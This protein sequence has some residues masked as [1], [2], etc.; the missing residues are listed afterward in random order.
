MPL[1]PSQYIFP[2][3]THLGHRQEIQTDRGM[4]RLA[5]AHEWP[6]PHV[7]KTQAQTHTLPLTVIVAVVTRM[8]SDPGCLQSDGLVI[9]YMS[10]QLFSFSFMNAGYIPDLFH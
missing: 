3:Q 6:T 4:P 8:T 2:T 10:S 1:N 7:R 5:S 9:K